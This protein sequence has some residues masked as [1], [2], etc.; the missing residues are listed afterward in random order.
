MKFFEDIKKNK[1]IDD[2]NAYTLISLKNRYVYFAVSKAAN[3]TIKWMLRTIEYEGTKY[4]IKNIHNWRE[5]PHVFPFQLAREDVAS[6]LTTDEHMFRF[7]FVRNPYTRLLSCYLDRIVRSAT[8]SKKRLYR[9]MEIDDI[10]KQVTFAD[11]VD[12]I[13]AQSPPQMDSHWRVQ[14]NDICFDT[15]SFSRVFHFEDLAGGLGTLEKEVFKTPK[16][17]LH[18]LTL[19]KSPSKTSAADRLH[20]YYTPYLQ[21][22]V[23][24]IYKADFDNF[25]YAPELQL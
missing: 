25:G 10:S 22:K 24:S 2:F 3:S 4:R 23:Y 15:V 19:N 6:L 11:F 21:E 13:S 20:E 14:T 1:T 16:A 18:D 5:A 17:I 8:V 7:A 12:A 9:Y